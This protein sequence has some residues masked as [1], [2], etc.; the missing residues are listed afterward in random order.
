MH[1]TKTVGLAFLLCTRCK[2]LKHEPWYPSICIDDWNHES[3]S[4]DP[5]LWN[6]VWHNNSK[7]REL[8]SLTS[9]H[10]PRTSESIHNV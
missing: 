10:I 6:R 7:I 2:I 8:Y 5:A 3:P 4:T 1:V 9:F